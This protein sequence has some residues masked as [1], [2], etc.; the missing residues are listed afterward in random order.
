[1]HEIIALVA[2][3]LIA[4]GFYGHLKH[5]KLSSR[6]LLTSFGLFLVLINLCMYL[7][8]IYVFNQDQVLFDNKSFITY[9]IGASLFAFILPFV[10]NLVENVV[11]IEVRQN[12][13]N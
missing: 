9:L 3:A 8:I 1:M 12:D 10:V 6:K 13:K 2:P 4:L 11:A 7:V 5:N